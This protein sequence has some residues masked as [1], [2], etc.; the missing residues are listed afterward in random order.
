MASIR[1]AK[2]DL[3]YLVDEVIGTALITQFN[4]P[5]KFQELEKV[6]DEIADF[7]EEMTIK[8]NNPVLAEGETKKKYFRKIYNELLAKVNTSFDTIHELSK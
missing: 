5:D 1:R 2:K 6:I 7:N 4:K 8:I 3:N